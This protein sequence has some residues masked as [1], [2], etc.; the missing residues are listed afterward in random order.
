MNSDLLL[1]WLI[2]NPTLRA[3]RLKILYKDIW[4]QEKRHKLGISH[5]SRCTICDETESSIHQ[6]FLCTNAIRIWNTVFNCIE[7]PLLAGGMTNQAIAELIQ[8]SNDLAL[9]I[10]KSAIFKLLI[11]I[12]RSSKLDNASVLKNVSYW[13]CINLRAISKKNRNNKNLINRLEDL[14]RKLSSPPY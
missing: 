8:V 3:I 7:T 2:N 6:L 14:M 1:L 13:I 11:Q 5:S 12:D 9:E 4:S 10:V